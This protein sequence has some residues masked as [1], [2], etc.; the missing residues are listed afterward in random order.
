MAQVQ[1]YAQFKTFGGNLSKKQ[2][3]AFYKHARLKML[4]KNT[5]IFLQGTP[6]NHYFI[7]LKGSVKIF[8]ASDKRQREIVTTLGPYVMKS[9]P[10][11]IPDGFL[12][13]PSASFTVPPGS[14]GVGFGGIQ[15]MS[16]PNFSQS[17]SAS[18]DLELIYVDQAHY[19]SHLYASHLSS[20]ALTSRSSSLRSMPAFS[21]LTNA[22]VHHLAADFTDNMYTGRGL[23]THPSDP[24]NRLIV[25][26]EAEARS[27]ELG[28]LFTCH[29]ESPSLTLTLRLSLRVCNPLL[30]LRGP[31]SPYPPPNSRLRH[32]DKRLRNRRRRA[33]HLLSQVQIL[34]QR[35]ERRR[36]DVRAPPADVQEARVG[37]LSCRGCEGRHE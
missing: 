22:Q 15:M 10:S 26:G 30:H 17:A 1:D 11:S 9:P 25:I 32:L 23:I 12:G 5:P 4:P 3:Q 24:F 28:E 37:Q 36:E 33:V 35:V 18:E 8:Q 16:G 29:L 13:R 2:L 34:V 14:P 20:Y 31:P 27:G 6:G 19:K 7:L 21:H